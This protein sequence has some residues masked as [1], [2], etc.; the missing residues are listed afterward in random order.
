MLELVLFAKL[1]L[2]GAH[3]FVEIIFFL[4][5]LHLVLD[6]TADLFLDLQDFDFALDDLQ[7]FLEPRQRSEFLENFLL[8]LDLDVEMGHE[9][10]A[11]SARLF[12][13]GQGADQFGRNFLAEPGVTFEGFIDAAH[14]GLLLGGI[15]LFVG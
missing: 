10:V 11:Q 7:Q 12:N 2:N 15:D 8:V 6:P 1:L 5:A 13:P 9:A 14:Q 4:A 3:L